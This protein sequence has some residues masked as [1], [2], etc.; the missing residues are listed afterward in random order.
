[1]WHFHAVE[2]LARV[3]SAGVE[4]TRAPAEIAMNARKRVQFR[5]YR[6]AGQ[7]KT[8]R[9]RAMTKDEIRRH[10]ATELR[11]KYEAGQ[12]VPGTEW[13]RSWALEIT[14]ATVSEGKGRGES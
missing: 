7:T 6:H 1:M 12:E 10:L 9:K 11:R 8:L 14:T 5:A 2:R 3:H 4:S 13:L